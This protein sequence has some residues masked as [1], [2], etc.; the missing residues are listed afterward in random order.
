VF[1]RGVD[2]DCPPTASQGD[3]PLGVPADEGGGGKPFHC[4]GKHTSSP[5][6]VQVNTPAHLPL[7]R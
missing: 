7:S 3:H 5:G 2:G 6:T 4:P 1:G